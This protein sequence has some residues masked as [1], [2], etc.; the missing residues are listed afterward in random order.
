MT[1]RVDTVR[2]QL[3]G[4]QTLLGDIR[5]EL[6]DLHSIAWERSRTSDDPKVRGG[7]RDYALDTHGNPTARHAL[8]I[9]KEATARACQ[10]LALALHEAGHVLRKGDDPGNTSRT[11]IT[12]AELAD[13]LAAQANRIAEGQPTSH[14]RLPQPRRDRAIKAMEQR[15]LKAEAEARGLRRRLDRAQADL[16]AI[17]RR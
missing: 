13:A 3:A 7:T 17:R 1:V 6:D 10:D 11:L 8:D 9:L 5:L 4:T 15:A 2:N 16:D 12:H 14:R